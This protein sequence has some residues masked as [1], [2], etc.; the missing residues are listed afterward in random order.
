MRKVFSS[1]EVSETTLVR[2]TLV[3][4][5]IDVTIQN[6]QSGRTAVPGF[7]PPAEIWVIDNEDYAGARRLVIETLA[8]LD[9][10]AEASPWDCASCGEANPPSFEFCWSCGRD[11]SSDSQ[12]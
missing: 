8:T 2:D 7:R 11:G 12:A 9:S 6:E 5:G 1:N 3:H 4:H 10:Q